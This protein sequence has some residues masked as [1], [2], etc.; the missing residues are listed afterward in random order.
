MPWQWAGRGER[1]NLAV[2]LVS[3]LLVKRGSLGC[4]LQVQLMGQQPLAGEILGQGGTPTAG[5]GQQ[6]H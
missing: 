2:S 5:K 6:P 3:D 1:K 4:G